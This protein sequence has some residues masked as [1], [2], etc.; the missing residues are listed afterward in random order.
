[1]GLGRKALK[2]LRKS[3]QKRFDKKLKPQNAKNVK[4]NILVTRR[5]TSTAAAA[6]AG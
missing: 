6:A 3:L 1:L 4:M 2:K 5:R